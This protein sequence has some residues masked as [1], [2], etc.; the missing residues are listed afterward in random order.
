MRM[1]RIFCDTRQNITQ[2]CETSWVN[3]YLMGKDGSRSCILLSPQKQI[4]R[5]DPLFRVHVPYGIY[6]RL[7]NASQIRIMNP[8]NEKV[9]SYYESFGYT[10][11]PKGDFLFRNIR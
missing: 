3:G 10:Y 6:A 4:S 11:A 7:I 9:K 2:S 8:I 1:S 5:P